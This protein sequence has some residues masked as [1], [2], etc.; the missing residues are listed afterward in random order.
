MPTSAEEFVQD[1]FTRG[2]IRRKSYRLAKDGV[3]SYGECEC[4][5][6]ELKKCILQ[7]WP[8][9][10]ASLGHFKSFV[11]T[12]VENSIV[13]LIRRRQ[14]AK[15]CQKKVVSLNTQMQHDGR[16]TQLAQLIGERELDNRLGRQRRL[17]DSELIDLRSDLEIEIAKLP[18][19]QQTLLL[20]LKTHSLNE[21]SEVMEVPRT[22]LIDWLSN[23]RETFEKAGL[24]KYI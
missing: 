6:Q 12:V 8:K 15:S 16:V 19:E 13:N 14:A 1:P 10:D 3:I 22:T 9:F 21:L 18:T 4:I 20:L 11:T 23:I 24:Q 7:S 5:E 2:L 17:N